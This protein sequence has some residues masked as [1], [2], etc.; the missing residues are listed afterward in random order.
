MRIPIHFPIY[1]HNKMLSFLLPISTPVDTKPQSPPPP[2]S[3]PDPD[4]WSMVPLY[5]NDGWDN[6]SFCSIDSM[7]AQ[8]WLALDKNDNEAALQLVEM[9]KE[10]YIVII[11]IT[12]LYMITLL[13]MVCCLFIISNELLRPQCGIMDHVDKLRVSLRENPPELPKSTHY[14]LKN[15]VR[16]HRDCDSCRFRL[17]AGTGK[18]DANTIYTCMIYAH[19]ELFDDYDWLMERLDMIRNEADDEWVDKKQ[20]KAKDTYEEKKER[21]RTVLEKTFKN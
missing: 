5:D 8:E 14:E 10:R 1:I 6:I 4:D 13:I 9:K 3:L 21:Y 20:T 2:T 19:K 11:C 7:T 15:M 12:E 18:C 17:H 16:I